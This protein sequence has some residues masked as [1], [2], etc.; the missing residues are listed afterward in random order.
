MSEQRTEQRLALQGGLKAVSGV[1]GHGK[2]KI[3]VDE[4]M[5]VVERFGLSSDA[6]AGIRDIAEA[7]TWGGGPF[8]ANYYSGLDESKVQAFERCGREIFGSTY[9]LGTNSGTAALHCAF[10]AVG[11]GPGKEVICPA[12]GFFAT[13]AAVVQAK[14]I[15]VFCDVDQ[16]L[17]MDPA[18]IEALITPRTVALAPTHL[19]GVVCDMDGIMAVARKHGL[20]VVEDVAQA[21]G[22]RCGDEYAGTIGDVGCFSISAYKIVGGGEGGLLLTDDE[23]LWERANQV[24]ECG[25]LWRPDRFA[26]PRYEGELFCGTNYRMSELEA[27]VNV[28]QLGKMEETVGRFRCARSSILSQ[29]KRFREIVPAQSNDPAGD[30]GY[31]LFFYPRTIEL[32]QKIVEALKA[33]GVGCSMRGES[34]RPDWH[35]Y[36]YMY[37]VTL[38]PGATEDGCPFQCPLYTEAGGRASYA[39]GDC[40]VADDLFCRKVG[41]GIN[42]WYSAGDCANVAVGINKVLGAYC[43]ED[44][45]AAAWQ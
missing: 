15:P 41:M 4:L 26:A 12:I 43:T 9:A 19:R 10:T 29:L 8:L 37:P 42:Q 16:S 40:P 31:D 45:A 17:C 22:G 38:T 5:A 35:I 2:P 23:R 36:S 27:A 1:E 21:C 20:R 30:V 6:M 13:A 32:G 24:A 3:G 7:D 18:K 28:V 39:E 25:G 14:G 33:E 44:A 34:E 11:V